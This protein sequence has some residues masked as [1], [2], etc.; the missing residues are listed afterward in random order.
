MSRKN[1]GYRR[2]AGISSICL[3]WRKSGNWVMVY[4]RILNQY[5][6]GEVIFV[7]FWPQNV[8]ILWKRFFDFT[9]ETFYMVFVTS[10]GKIWN[11]NLTCG[12]LCLEQLNHEPKFVHAK[13]D[14][15]A[16]FPHLRYD[17]LKSLFRVCRFSQVEVLG[18]K[19]NENSCWIIV[20]FESSIRK[21]ILY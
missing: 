16:H 9:I 15:R 2:R 17:W 11:L 8:E 20:E 12:G 6:R 13:G 14:F 3:A 10:W 19:R 5:R 1:D 21:K 18:C 4:G 7:F